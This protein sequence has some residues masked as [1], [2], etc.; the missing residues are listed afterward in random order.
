MYRASRTKDAISPEKMDEL[1]SM[2]WFRMGQS[3]FTTEFL[4]NGFEFYDTVWLRQNLKKLTLSSWFSQEKKKNIFQMELTV[5]PPSSEHSLLYSKYREQMPD[6]WPNSLESILGGPAD[7]NISNTQTL[8]L[9]YDDTLAAALVFDAG[10]KSTAAI[11]NFY[12]PKFAKYSP[13]KYL[14]Y[15][16]M[17]HSQV[18]GFDYFYPGYFAPG[19]SHFNYKLEFHPPSL[20]FFTV[21]TAEWRPISQFKSQDFPM[22]IMKEKLASLIALF[23]EYDMK[24][25]LIFNPNFTALR[26]SKWECPM[27]AYIPSGGKSGKEYAVAYYTNGRKYCLFD[28]SEWDYSEFLEE[29]GD[30]TICYQVQNLKEPI[31]SFEDPTV[32]AINLFLSREIRIGNN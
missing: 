23:T 29:K 25:T 24:S 17:E 32:L 3:M 6:T 27:V 7:S 5:G 15:A 14:Y 2:G 28:C 31:S 12:D 26:S 9:Y 30:K 8:S 10:Y 16:V 13:G 4:Q 22:H 11:A 19:N 20:E 21:N 1:L 18:S